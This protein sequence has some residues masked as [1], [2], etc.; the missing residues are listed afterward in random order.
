MTTPQLDKSY[1]WE[2]LEDRWYQ[3]WM[4]QGYF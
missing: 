4:D 1:N 3:H 2:K